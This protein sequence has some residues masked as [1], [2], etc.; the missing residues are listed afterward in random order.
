MPANAAAR[1]LRR[2][3]GSRSPRRCARGRARP[4]TAADQRQ[5]SGRHARASWRSAA[6]GSASATIGA[7][8]RPAQRHRVLHRPFEQHADEQQHDEVE[9][10]RGHDLV[11]AEP[12]LAASA[13]P[14]MQQ[15]AG[16]RRRRPASAGTAAAAA[17]RPRR[18]PDG[19]GG[20]RARIELALGADVPEPRP[21]RDRRREPGQD[22]RRGAGQRLAPAR[23][24]S[25]SSP[26][27]SAA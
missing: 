16:Q 15:R 18:E 17:V 21:E 6:A 9:Q 2:R 26:P 3:R 25:R 24:A 8:L 7:D 22:Q 14:S 19:D 13:G 23:T 1:A 10:Q 5:R 12:Q 20:E 27:P 4:A 11:D